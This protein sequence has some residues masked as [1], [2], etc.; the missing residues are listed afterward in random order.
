MREKKTDLD[1]GV[2]TDPLDPCSSSP[3]L[4]VVHLERRILGELGAAF[5][6]LERLGA[7]VRPLVH[8]QRRL[9][10]ERFAALGADV[11][12][13]AALVHLKRRPDAK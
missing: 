1:Q 9:G 5:G 10:A 7:R 8:L 12:Q 11:P 2:G 13:V 4:P 3:W 6:A